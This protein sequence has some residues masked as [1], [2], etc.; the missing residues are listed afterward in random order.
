MLAGPG[1]P[2]DGACISQSAPYSFLPLILVG[3]WGWWV[4][5]GVAGRIGTKEQCLSHASLILQAFIPS[6]VLLPLTQDT[7]SCLLE[8]SGSWGSGAGIGSWLSTKE[9]YSFCLAPLTPCEKEQVGQ[10]WACSKSQVNHKHIHIQPQKPPGAR[11]MP[12]PHLLWNHSRCHEGQYEDFI[13][14]S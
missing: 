7:L 3:W 1:S 12:L 11:I 14:E 8:V 2:L 9:T 13:A 10:G 4:P 6:P 5:V